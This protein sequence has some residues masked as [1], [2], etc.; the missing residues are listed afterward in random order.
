MTLGH[1]VELHARMHVLIDG[2]ASSGEVVLCL[3]VPPVVPR[4]HPGHPSGERR[5]PS[6]EGTEGDACVEIGP[7]RVLEAGLAEKAQSNR[8]KEEHKEQR[9]PRVPAGFEERA[10]DEERNRNHSRNEAPQLALPIEPIQNIQA[11][12]SKRCYREG[13]IAALAHRGG[14]HRIVELQPEPD[15]RQHDDSHDVR[16]HAADAYNENLHRLDALDA[17][18]HPPASA[19]WRPP[20]CRRPD[21]FLDGSSRLGHGVARTTLNGACGSRAQ[22]GTAL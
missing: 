18:L 6:D 7:L 3:A 8:N 5:K 20:R 14:G 11:H 12:D 10:C 22:G 9:C 15:I 17:G 16:Q 1:V 21:R 19:R 13:S 4:D 2:P